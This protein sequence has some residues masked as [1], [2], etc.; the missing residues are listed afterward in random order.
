[1]KRLLA[2]LLCLGLLAVPARAAVPGWAEDAYAALDARGIPLVATALGPGT[3]DV[4]Q[5]GLAQAA[6]VIGS[7]GRGVSPQVLE[8]CDLTVKIP[9]RPRC[10]SL[11]AAVAAGVILWELYR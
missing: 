10:E 9:M 11:N 3:R 7:E 4:R 6:V 2:L 5:A 8:R 1:M